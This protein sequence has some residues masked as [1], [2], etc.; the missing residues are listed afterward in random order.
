MTRCNQPGCPGTIVDGYCDVCGSPGPVS[1]SADAPGPGNGQKTMTPDL[2]GAR[3]TQPGCPGT[4][5]DG[6]CD[7]CGS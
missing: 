3:C 5:V 2:S 6:Y 1:T 4:I 7:V